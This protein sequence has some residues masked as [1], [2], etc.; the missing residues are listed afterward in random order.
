MAETSSEVLPTPAKQKRKGG[1]FRFLFMLLVILA[2]VG[3]VIYHFS[4]INSMKFFLVPEADKLVVKK[5]ILFLSGNEPYVPSNPDDKWIYSPIDLPNGFGA[6][7]R[8]FDSLA[9]LNHSFATV[10]IGGSKKLIF[11]DKEDDYRKGI[12]YLKRLGELEGLKPEQVKLIMALTADVDYIEA[13][14]SYLGVEMTLEKALKKFKQAETYGTGRFA[15]AP[16]W[17]TKVERLLDIIRATKA[18]AI[19]KPVPAVRNEFPDTGDSVPPAEN[20]PDPLVDLPSLQKND[21]APAAPTG[22]G[23]PASQPP[24]GI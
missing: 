24:Q 5:G 6:Q 10:L 12:A 19:P 3:F 11:S 15:D 18:G 7:Q 21:S 1:G 14:R 2:L 20:D 17:I 22:V 9:E 13:K 8:A 23:V 16:K 4:V